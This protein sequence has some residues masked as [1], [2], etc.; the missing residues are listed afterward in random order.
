MPYKR[1][2]NEEHDTYYEVQLLR[3]Q[4]QQM[5]RDIE[6]ALTDVIQNMLVAFRTENGR[7]ESGGAESSAAVRE[8]PT[9]ILSTAVREPGG[10]EGSPA[11]VGGSPGWAI[12][13]VVRVTPARVG[14]VCNIRADTIA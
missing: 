3:W 9:G 13:T 12:A 11:A 14:L 7:S 10:A 1:Q 2:A 4:M 5:V 6:A 8:S